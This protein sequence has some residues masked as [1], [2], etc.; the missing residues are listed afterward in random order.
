[1][2]SFGGISI[3]IGAKSMETKSSAAMESTIGLTITG[4]LI[5]K[6][7]RDGEREEQASP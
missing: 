3:D 7:L 6:L 4:T 5:W 2:N 1:M